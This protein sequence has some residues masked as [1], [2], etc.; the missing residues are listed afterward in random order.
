MQADARSLFPHRIEGYSRNHYTN[1]INNG[2][3]NNE[4]KR[5]RES[6]EVHEERYL[7]L[8]LQGIFEVE[9]NS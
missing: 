2:R 9:R 6:T 1:A 3:Q 5:S 7:S 8:I 4:V